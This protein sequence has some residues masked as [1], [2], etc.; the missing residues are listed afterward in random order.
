MNKYKYSI[1]KNVS[2]SEYD[3]Q[4]VIEAYRVYY[5][6]INLDIVDSLLMVTKSNSYNYKNKDILIKHSDNLKQAIEIV[7]N[8]NNGEY[9]ILSIY[10]NN[11]NLIG[12]GRIK[13][14]KN[15]AYLNELLSLKDLDIYKDTLIFLEKYLIKKGISIIKIEITRHNPLYLSSAFNLNY[16]E[17]PE[18][19]KDKIYILSKEIN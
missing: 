2:L 14:Q 15:Y 17:L 3:K 5:S 4:K 1:N 18:D 7:N 13:Y 10:D 8:L 12:F 19:I 9:D 16:I 6:K 11:D